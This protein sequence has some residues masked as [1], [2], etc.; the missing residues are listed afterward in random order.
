ME[1]GDR[2]T[3][4]QAQRLDQLIKLDKHL[5]TAQNYQDGQ[6]EI[7]TSEGKLPLDV[8][9]HLRFTFWRMRKGRLESLTKEGLGNVGYQLL[10]RLV[11]R[12]GRT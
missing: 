1:R 4:V 11:E 7:T 5:Q 12:H 2:A 9:N 6:I 3:S 10:G 8:D